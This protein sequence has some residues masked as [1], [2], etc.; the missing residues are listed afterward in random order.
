[1]DIFVPEA[2]DDA[3][4]ANMTDI[5]H[6]LKFESDIICWGNSNLNPR[7]YKDVLAY[8][9][10]YSRPVRFVRWGEELPAVGLDVLLQR[11]VLHFLETGR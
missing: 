6:A 10:K 3:T 11:S 1:M 7:F 9:E 8:A 5:K 4:A 2:V